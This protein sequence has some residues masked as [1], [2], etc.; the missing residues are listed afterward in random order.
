MSN[1]KDTVQVES[2]ELANSVSTAAQPLAK[3]SWFRDIL[4]YA[5]MI[6]FALCFVILLF[7]FGFRICTVSGPS[8][9]NTLF[10]GEQLVISDVFYEPKRNDVVVF[11]HLGNLKEPVVKRVI[12]VAGETVSIDYTM[13]SMTVTV[14][15]ADGKTTQVLEEPYMYYDTDSIRFLND[16][17][18]V[19][20]EEQLF[21][22]GD[23][24]NHSTDSRSQEIGL[25]DTRFVL[26]KVLFRI[27]PLAR[28]GAIN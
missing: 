5:E 26:G 22:M 12:A 16:A 21:V 11:H 23:N 8:M 13:T 17:T 1:K 28:F 20:G 10:H 2:V 6:V 18:F 27:A 14:T 19:V 3:K 25:V 9:E 4:D 24:R 15:S 7:S